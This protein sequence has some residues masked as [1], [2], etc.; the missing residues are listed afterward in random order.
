MREG[1]LFQIVY[2]LL[3]KGKA[4]APEL[5]AKFE[6][7]IR[8]IYRDLDVL[9]GAGIPVYTETGRNGGISLM[10]DFVLDRVLF[11]EEEK[12]EILTRLQSLNALPNL[13]G[14]AALDKLSALFQSRSDNW[15]EVDFSRWSDTTGDNEK[16]EAVKSAILSKKAMRITYAG[17]NSSIGE[18]IVCPRK[19]IY[20]SKAWYLQAYCTKRCAYRTF[21]LT[22]ILD[23]QVLKNEFSSEQLPEPKAAPQPE[24]KYARLL[25]RFP[26]EAAYRVFD[27]FDVDQINCRE[28]GGLLVSARLPEDDWLTGYLLSFGTQLEILEPVYLRARIAREARRIFEQNK[29]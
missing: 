9:S 20:K 11:S 13:R 7:S 1:R 27:E 19:L 8:T 2:Y 5:A 26:K 3:D 29:C 25:L 4:T 18:R 22:R 16:F 14:N 15:L 12:Q 10:H 23:W 28:D 21:K 17:S 24:C 6:V